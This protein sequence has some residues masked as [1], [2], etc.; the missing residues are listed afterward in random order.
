VQAVLSASPLGGN[1]TF[2]PMTDGGPSRYRSNKTVTSPTPPQRPTPSSEKPK[3][4]P[5][6]ARTKANDG[7]KWDD[8]AGKSKPAKKPSYSVSK[9]QKTKRNKTSGRDR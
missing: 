5:K 8:N 7:Y 1:D 4:K 6:P 9:G 3:P 2:S